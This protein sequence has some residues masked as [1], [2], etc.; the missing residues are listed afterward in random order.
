MPRVLPNNGLAVK[1]LQRSEQKTTF[2]N[3]SSKVS[4]K[5]VKV[6]LRMDFSRR[7]RQDVLPYQT[8]ASF[9]NNPKA[10][11]KNFEILAHLLLDRVVKEIRKSHRTVSQD[12]SW[13]DKMLKRMNEEPSH[14]DVEV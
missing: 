10:A 1:K 7:A 8:V 12:C 13:V 14:G 5:E 4:T 11:G 2:E 3:W 9:N 6:N